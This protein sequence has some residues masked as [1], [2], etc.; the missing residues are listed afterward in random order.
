MNKNT[1]RTASHTLYRQDRHA[2]HNNTGAQRRHEAQPAHTAGTGRCM[3]HKRRRRFNQ[4]RLDSTRPQALRQRSQGQL[5]TSRMPAAGFALLLLLL[6]SCSKQHV[7]QT[8]LGN[9]VS[10]LSL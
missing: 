5:C 2:K 4:R 8:L 1:T 10:Q 7:H 9:H 6:L 3:S